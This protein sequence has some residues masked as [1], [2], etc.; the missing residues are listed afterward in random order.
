MKNEKNEMKIYEFYNLYQFQP[1]TFKVDLQMAK[2]LYF[3]NQQ[4]IGQLQIF[5]FI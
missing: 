4:Y 1:V 3:W 2:Y 5:T